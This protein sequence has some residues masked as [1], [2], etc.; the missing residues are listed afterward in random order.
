MKLFLPA[1]AAAALIAPAAA[2][3]MTVGVDIPRL[4]VA[5]YH[6]P[7]VAMWLQTPD[8]KPAANLAVWYDVEMRNDEGEDWLKDLRQ[9]WRRIGRS[10]DMPVDGVSGP[11]RAPGAHEVT[12]DEK[13]ND[14]APGEYEFMI[15]AVREVGGRELLHGAVQWP[16]KEETTIRLEGGRELGPV[17][18]TL[19][20]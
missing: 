5:E 10:T 1:T 19:K 20:P 14:L 9:W 11:T 18:L 4:D 12:F 8:G 17:I 3:D 2:A 13:L 6:R 15:E 16:P 7:Y